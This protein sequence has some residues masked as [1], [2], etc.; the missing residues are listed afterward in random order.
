MAQDGSFEEMERAIGCLI[1]RDGQNDE[2]LTWDALQ[3]HFAWASKV[4]AA[5]G[6]LDRGDMGQFGRLIDTRENRLWWAT[7]YGIDLEQ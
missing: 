3:A 1:W 4:P 6:L 2:S 5:L 7:E